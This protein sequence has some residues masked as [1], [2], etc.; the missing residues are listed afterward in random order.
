MSDAPHID[1]RLIDLLY[2]ELSEEAEATLRSEIQRDEELAAAWSALVTIEEG[3]GRPEP[4]EAP[5]RVRQNAL[6]EARLKLDARKQRAPWWASI[7]LPSGVLAAAAAVGLTLLLP[8]L[9]GPRTDQTAITPMPV[10][11]EEGP[12]AATTE[13]AMEVAE[14]HA[15][16]DSAEEES[17]PLMAV[18]R[19][20]DED[21]EVGA[22]PSALQQRSSERTP[23]AAR[24]TTRA[25][26]AASGSEDEGLG[27]GWAPIG[28]GS[29]S[30]GVGSM[31]GHGAGRAA[32]TDTRR[33]SFAPRPQPSGNGERQLAQDTPSSATGG[34]RT[35]DDVAASAP[36]ARSA[37]PPPAPPRAGAPP[38][39]EQQ[40]GASMVDHDH[41]ELAEAEPEHAGPAAEPAPSARG[42]AVRQRETR[43]APSSAPLSDDHMDV[44]LEGADADPDARLVRRIE[45]MDRDDPRRPALMR[46][47]AER[48]SARG[49][50]T[51]ANEWWRRIVREY[52]DSD[53]ARSARE[54]LQR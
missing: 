38:Q 8:S 28:S 39:R 22:R 45:R 54:H 21:T 27:V 48:A 13:V 17:E 3:L 50:V 51:R 43:G 33:E 36:E 4:V 18:A 10:A 40:P 26:R 30:S 46:E 41:H 42:E 53:E 6:R 9:T 44:E 1:P 15:M 2:G 32:P 7:W 29:E 12:D 47:A 31:G 14:P 37:S 20:V 35:R 49:D 34:A 52:P 11:M 23:T 25:R 16:E 24:P 19:E 5:A